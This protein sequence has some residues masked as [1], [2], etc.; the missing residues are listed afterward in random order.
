MKKTSHFMILIYKFINQIK[1]IIMPNKYV[2]FVSDSHLIECISEL[3]TKYL[4]AKTSYTKKDFNKNKVDVFKMLFDKKFN[5]L[6]DE[7]LIEKEISRQVDRTIV[8]AIGDFHEKILSGV[9]GYSK[10]PSGI[11][12][13]S[14]DNKIFIE[15]KNKH[16]T[17]KGE[18]NKSIFTKLKGEIDK[19]PGSKAYFARILDKKSTN[20]Q[21]CFSHKD[22]EYTNGNIL[23]ISGDQLYKIITGKDNSLFQL[24]KKLPLAIDDFLITIDKDN[25]SDNVKSTAMKEFTADTSISNRSIIDEITFSNYNYYLGFDEL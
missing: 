16:N 24:Y 10:V 2:D 13:K 7:N 22:T 3:Y 25:K 11:D 17:V 5:N 1:R 8:N 14:D 21:W 4:N 19:N 9:I 12:I 20:K 15:L 23:I 18:D 6:D